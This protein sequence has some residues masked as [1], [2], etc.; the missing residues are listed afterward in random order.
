LF[1]KGRKHFSA[2]LQTMKDKIGA[3]H[4]PN[5]DKILVSTII[6]ASGS[7]FPIMLILH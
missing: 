3:S 1:D 6:A 4:C 7:K 2:L 5:R